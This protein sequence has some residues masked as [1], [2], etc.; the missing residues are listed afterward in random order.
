M[1]SVFDFF[2]CLPRCKRRKLKSLPESVTV[3]PQPTLHTFHPE[4]LP[5]PT[6]LIPAM[7]TSKVPAVGVDESDMHDVLGAI[8]GRGIYEVAL[9]RDVYRISAPRKLTRHERRKFGG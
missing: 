1:F 6:T 9:D 5:P 2:L 4:P 3:S 8:F 7:E